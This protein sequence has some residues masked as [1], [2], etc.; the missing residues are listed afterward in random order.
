MLVGQDWSL[1]SSC[2]C[3]RSHTGPRKETDVFRRARY[4]LAQTIAQRYDS[5][6]RAARPRDNNTGPEGSND[7]ILPRINRPALSSYDVH[8]NRCN[9]QLC[10][11]HS[12]WSYAAGAGW[13]DGTAMSARPRVAIRSSG[14]AYR[15]L[16]R[17]ACARRVGPRPPDPQCP[18]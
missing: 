9:D 4:W 18:V 8:C 16:Y 15:A 12:A 1:K 14:P 17:A 5:L 2:P 13:D 3:Y 10:T 11:G 6:E 7:R